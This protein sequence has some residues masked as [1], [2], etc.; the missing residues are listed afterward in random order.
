[1]LALLPAKP[2][3]DEEKNNLKP[4][5]T[6]ARLAED[7]FWSKD[8]PYDGVVRGAM[9]STTIMLVIPAKHALLLYD[10]SNQ[11]KGPQLTSFRN[12]GA[13]LY[14]PTG[15]TT[16][17]SPQ[18]IKS[19]L[20]SD[21]QGEYEKATKAMIEKG[22]ALQLKP[23]DPWVAAGAGERYAIVDPANNRIMS[24][25]WTG[26]LLQVQSVRNTELDLLIPTALNSTPNEEDALKKYVQSRKARLKEIRI[27]L[28]PASIKALVSQRAVANAKASTFQASISADDVVLDYTDLHKLFVYRL[29]G[30]NNQLELVAMRDYTLDVGLELQDAEFRNQD[31]AREIFE[32]MKAHVAGHNL[33]LAM[34][35][36]KFTLKLNP[37]L[38]KEIEKSPSSK[39]LKKHPDWQA[40]LDAAMKAAEKIEAD[41]EERRKKS[42]EAKKLQNQP[43]K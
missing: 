6:R 37:F 25:E 1:M 5:Q 14:V 17:P 43:K 30:A 11:D 2:T 21:I 13:E 28:D 20:P 31:Y 27:E 24:Y 7:E 23:S 22:G 19:K 38:Y 26:K 16:T 29:Q 42:E 34:L 3:A 36:M 4:Y 33:E 9:A 8:H 40:T 10:V 35:A 41:R 12:Y 15:L 39:E 32:D 18:D